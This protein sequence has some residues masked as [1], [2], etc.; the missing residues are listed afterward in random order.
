MRSSSMKQLSRCPFTEFKIDRAFVDGSIDHPNRRAI[1]ESSILMGK[2][3]GVTTVAEGV[4]TE[5]D[6]RLLKELGCE[7]GQGYFA[8]R[9]MPAN[10]LIGWIRENRLRLTSMFT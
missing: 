1:L 6:W 4:E 2:R 9:P 3:L 8:G 10:E 7:V 5:A